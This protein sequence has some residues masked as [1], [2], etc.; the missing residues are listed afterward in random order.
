MNGDDL[1]AFLT[2]EQLAQRWLLSTRQVR[3]IIAAEKI[4]VHRI[5]RPVRI[6][7]AAIEA[8]E[9]NQCSDVHPNKSN[10]ISKKTGGF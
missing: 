1:P 5:G 4:H 8:F 6:S 10:K 2:T 3:R 9:A 7:R